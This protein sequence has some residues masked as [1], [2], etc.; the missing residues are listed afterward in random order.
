MASSVTDSGDFNA[1]ASADAAD[2]AFDAAFQTE[3]AKP[4]PAAEAVGSTPTPEPAETKSTETAEVAG[5]TPVAEAKPVAPEAQDTPEYQNLLAKYGG[6]K[7]AAAKSYWETVKATAQLAKEKEELAAKLA[8]YEAQGSTPKAEQAQQAVKE[9]PTELRRYDEK[10]RSV[11]TEFQATQKERGK[12]VTEGERLDNVLLA[13]D[14]ELNSNDLTVDRDE[15]TRKI[16]TAMRERRAVSN[17]V[18]HLDSKLKGFDYT[19]QDLTDRR[20]MREAILEQAKELQTAREAKARFEEDQEV[21]SFKGTW[22]GT[23]EKVSKDPTIIPAVLSAKFDKYVRAL[24]MAHVATGKPIEDVDKFVRD[25]AVEYM[26]GAKEFH[27][28]QS[29][30]YA[31]LKKDDA[32]TSSPEGG[33]ALASE[34]KRPRSDWTQAQWAAYE[35]SIQL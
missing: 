28:V 18:A 12:Y 22:D 6:D 8:A 29:T 23:I 11:E 1:A 13:L 30:E 31:K 9:I 4:E 35:E 24:G 15:V 21:V 34:T 19:W 26:S 5:S 25:A 16:V 10:I 17:Y 14:S 27:Q 2:A 33:A 20:A 3:I 7:N 32:K